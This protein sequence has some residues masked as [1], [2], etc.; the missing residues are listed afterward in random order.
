MILLKTIVG[1]KD[2]DIAILRL[3][4][5]IEPYSQIGVQRSQSLQFDNY[6]HQDLKDSESDSE[7]DS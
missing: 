6:V 1:I 7:Q 2:L 5:F 3:L 4:T